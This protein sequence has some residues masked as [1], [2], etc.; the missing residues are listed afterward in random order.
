MISSLHSGQGTN[1]K[2][3]CGGIDPKVDAD[4]DMIER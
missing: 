4:E 1:E 2:S 3:S